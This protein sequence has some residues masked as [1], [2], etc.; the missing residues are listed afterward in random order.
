MSTIMKTD[1]NIEQNQG[2]TLRVISDKHQAKCYNLTI[3]TS[4]QNKKNP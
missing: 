3:R 1:F 2:S 4:E